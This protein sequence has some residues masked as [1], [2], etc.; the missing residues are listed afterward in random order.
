MNRFQPTISVHQNVVSSFVE[1]LQ[2]IERDLLLLFKKYGINE[3]I[4]MAVV[5]GKPHFHI[6]IDTIIDGRTQEISSKCG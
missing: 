2:P 3:G 4:T 1:E 5:E 6:N